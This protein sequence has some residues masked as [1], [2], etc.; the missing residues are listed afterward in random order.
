MDGKW[1]VLSQAYDGCSRPPTKSVWISTQ[2]GTL[3]LLDSVD[4][5]FPAVVILKLCLSL[6][7]AIWMVPCAT[8]PLLFI[9]KSGDRIVY[10]RGNIHGSSS[11][12][13]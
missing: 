9:V 1:I 2:P 4:N 12:P 7:S 13:S 11:S 5:V 6:C 8:L 3:L 10:L